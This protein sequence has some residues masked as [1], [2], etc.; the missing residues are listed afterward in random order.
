MFGLG[1]LERDLAARAREVEG[2][3]LTPQRRLLTA[4]RFQQRVG[5]GLGLLRRSVTHLFR[6]P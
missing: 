5:L 2:L 6:V 1:P 4:Q 3:K